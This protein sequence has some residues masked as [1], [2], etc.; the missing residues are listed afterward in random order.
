MDRFD[1]VAAGDLDERRR[2]GGAGAT[3]RASWHP[4][5]ELGDGVTVGLLPAATLSGRL[6]FALLGG[7]LLRR[8]ARPC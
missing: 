1:L 4:R 7:S 2:C 5:C 3:A 8:R 6:A